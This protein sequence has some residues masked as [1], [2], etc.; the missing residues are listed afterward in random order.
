MYY[1]TEKISISSAKDC[2]S[3]YIYIFFFVC[4]PTFLETVNSLIIVTS[5]S[6]CKIKCKDL[7]T[8]LNSML[9]LRLFVMDQ[10]ECA[11]YDT[12]GERGKRRHLVL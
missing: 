7:I 10:Q 9:S 8:V 3:I 11:M 5:T 1:L 6:I 12:G 4:R 2:D